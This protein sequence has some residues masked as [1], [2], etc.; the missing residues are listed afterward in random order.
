[1]TN[2]PDET[3]MAQKNKIESLVGIEKDRALE[4]LWRNLGNVPFDEDAEGR[5]VS[6]A[7]FVHFP[8]GT[9]VED[10]WHWFDEQHS[11][12]VVW[13]MYELDRK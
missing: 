10:I 4:E 11:K 8:V 3:G 5:M 13:L 6:A 7:S 9:E 2:H 12:G 1:M